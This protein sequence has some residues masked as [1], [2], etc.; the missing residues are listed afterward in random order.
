MD[1]IK[2][3]NI[4][5]IL[6]LVCFN[7]VSFGQNTSDNVPVN[8]SNWEFDVA[9]YIWFSS[10]KGNVG[11]L[12]QTV[13]VEA[14]FKDILDQLSFGILVHGEAQKG[15][16]TI[17]TDLVY[18]KIKEEGNLINGLVRTEVEIDQTILELGAGYTFVNITDFLTLDALFGLRYFGLKPGLTVAQQNDLTK[19]LDFIDPYLGI[20][21]RTVNEKWINSARFDVG[22][23]GIGSKIS[24]K[25]NLLIGYQFSDLFSLHLGYQG[26]DV[27][28]EDDNS[29]TYDMYTGGI[30]TGFNF[31][32]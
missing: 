4:V 29:F 17:M 11:F 8:E 9:P 20:R 32:F 22:G 21:F 18:L 12:N 7:S 3:K 5:I 19:N 24:W 26:Y 10:I 15:S 27:D 6:L 30:I 16:W 13:P 14:E 28:Y 25:L 23:F 1:S 31:N 2:M